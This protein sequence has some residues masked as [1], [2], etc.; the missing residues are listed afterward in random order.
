MGTPGC[1][2]RKKI[3]HMGG[4]RFE[5][6]LKKLSFEAGDDGAPRE[7]ARWV[8]RKKKKT[9]CPLRSG[10][11]GGRRSEEMGFGPNRKNRSILL[12]SGEDRRPKRSCSWEGTPSGY[13]NGEDQSQKIIVDW[14]RGDENLRDL[15]IVSANEI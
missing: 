5:N 14:K 9:R 6:M 10:R 11:G 12:K 2:L 4:R 7:G 15:Q 3:V 13:V 8:N 1:L